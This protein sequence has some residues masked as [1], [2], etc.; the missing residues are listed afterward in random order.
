VLKPTKEIANILNFTPPLPAYK[1]WIMYR[2]QPGCVRISSAV[3]TGGMK[4]K[5]C[6]TEEKED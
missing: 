5:V 2:E 6:L 4:V 3:I 1:T